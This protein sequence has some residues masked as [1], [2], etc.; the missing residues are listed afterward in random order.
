MFSKAKAK[1]E[2]APVTPKL[3]A[4]DSP[5]PAA[6]KRGGSSSKSSGKSSGVPSL[7][8]ADV[9]LK[10]TLTAAGEI[11]LDGDLDGDVRA[12][13]L[14]V[15]EK[16]SVKGEIV[17]ETVTV[18]GRVEGSIRARAVTLASTSHIEGDILHSALSVETGA[19]F[20]G[21]CRHSDD[22][23]SE[24]AAKELR[25]KST[26]RTPIVSTT[27]TASS[28]P[29]DTPVSKPSDI[30]PASASSGNGVDTGSLRTTSRSGLQSYT[31][32]S[33]LR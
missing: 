30:A 28:E 7:I 31:Q 19:Y 8:S 14:I 12:I 3:A 25:N 24:S 29:A 33:P 23:L 16:A 32:K 4:E 26:A 15:G 2:E 17:C 10:G 13:A 1:P 5:R 21:N 20:E 6:L 22:P 18:R 9:S 27:K 11:Q